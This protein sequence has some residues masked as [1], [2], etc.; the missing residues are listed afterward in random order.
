MSWQPA[1]YCA[2][3]GSVA[4]N[5]FGWAGEAANGCGRFSGTSIEEFADC[6][7]AELRAGNKVALGF[8][9]PLFVPLRR[10]PEDLTK[11]RN[12]DGSRAWS[13]AAGA[14]SLATV[15]TAWILSRIRKAVSPE[16]PLFFAWAKFRESASG[17]LLWEAFV[18]GKTKTE[19]HQEDASAAVGAFVDSLPDPSSANIICESEVFSLVAASAL[20]ARWPGADSLL[21]EPCLVLSP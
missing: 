1:V 9:C 15:E 18:T 2:D 11:A 10:K 16:P 17:L 12:G 5:R 14:T 20:R 6:V 8:E 21:N 3:A 13:A 7:A 19:S 4:R